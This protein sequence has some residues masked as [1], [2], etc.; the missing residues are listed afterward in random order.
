[1]GHA[2]DLIKLRTRMVDAVGAG[3]VGEDADTYKM[4]LI[5]ILNEAERKRQKAEAGI[6]N[7]RNQVTMMEGQVNAYSQMGS[8]IYA[9]LDGYVKIAEKTAAEESR[10]DRERAER[11][12]EEAEDV[13]YSDYEPT[14]EELAEHGY[15]VPEVTRDEMSASEKRSDT[16]AR[17]R[18]HNLWQEANG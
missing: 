13:D 18:A 2:E 12:A 14:D 11:E 4:T 9:V 6:A 8:I 10:R 1:M 5:Q 16:A 15:P 7:M 3:V 17:K